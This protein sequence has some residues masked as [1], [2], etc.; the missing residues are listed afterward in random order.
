[1][2]PSK[3]ERLAEFLRRL[4]A[5][6]AATDAASARRLIEETLNVEDEMT[7]IPFDP[8]AWE[9]DGRM[10]PAQD[11]QVRSVAGRSDLRRLVSRGHDTFIRDNGA[12]AIRTRRTKQVLL[13]KPGADGREVDDE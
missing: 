10:Y 5:A 9:T 6:P 12:I 13:R 1:L 7:D 8:A 2:I 4:G 3:A 11:D